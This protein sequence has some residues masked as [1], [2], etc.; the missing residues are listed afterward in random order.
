MID[1]RCSFCGK[2]IPKG[3]GKIIA[4]KS[5]DLLFIC[6][7]KC[8][9]NLKMGRKSQRT[10]WTER[11]AKTKM[12]G[13]KTEKKVVKKEKIEKPKRKRIPKKQRRELRRKKKLEKK[14]TKKPSEKKKTE[15]K[16]KKK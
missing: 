1:M 14:K 3:T 2:T 4:S 15:K 6:T 10:R 9:R 8:E 11:Y 13:K 12:E 16:P 5:G 7:M